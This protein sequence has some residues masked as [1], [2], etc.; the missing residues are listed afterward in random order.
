MTRLAY[1]AAVAGVVAMASPATAGVL[2]LEAQIQAGG[3]VGKGFRGERQDEAFHDHA[4]GASYGALIGIEFLFIDGWIEHNQYVNDARSAGSGVNGTWTQFMVG[5]DI[6]FD[7]GELVGKPPLLG[8]KDKRHHSGYG[9][10]G[11]GVGFGVGTGQQVDPPLDNAQITD[12]GAVGQVHLDFG[13]R[14]NQVMSI[15]IHIPVQVN[16]LFR[17][18]PDAFA[19]DESSWYGEYNVSGFVT[20]RANFAI[21]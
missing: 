3:M 6:Q 17:N 13:Y 21:K 8:E 18:Q 16:W 14:L 5:M 7:I 19:N 4:R 1:V 2:E 15:G 11:I 10:L 9:A 20:L 12:K